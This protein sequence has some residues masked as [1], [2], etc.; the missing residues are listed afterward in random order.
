MGLSGLFLV[1]IA[2]VVLAGCAGAGG[3]AAG[4]PVGSPGGPP[5][6]SGGVIEA[7]EVDGEDRGAGEVVEDTDRGDRA[8]LFDA[9]PGVGRVTVL[10]DLDVVDGAADDSGDRVAVD[11]GDDTERAEVV[12]DIGSGGAVL[13]DTDAGEAAVLYDID[14]GDDTDDGGNDEGVDGLDGD[15][16]DDGGRAV[17]DGDDADAADDVDDSGGDADAVDGVSD[18]G[19][20][21]ADGD[22]GGGSGVRFVVDGF[23]GVLVEGPCGGGGPVCPPATGVAPIDAGGRLV[24]SSYREDW[25]PWVGRVLDMCD[26]HEAYVAL[27]GEH[28]IK[29]DNGIDYSAT[30]SSLD[31]ERILEERGWRPIVCSDA[32]AAIPRWKCWEDDFEEFR[33]FMDEF[34]GVMEYEEV[35]ASVESAGWEC[36]DAAAQRL[37]YVYVTTGGPMQPTS[38]VEAAVEG[39]LA[40]VA[41][42]GARVRGERLGFLGRIP[43]METRE[44]A[45][46]VLPATVS[47]TDGV[48]RGLAQN[49]SEQL[50]ARD[51][52]V[53]ATDPTGGEGEWRFPLTVQPGEPLPFEIENW[54]GTRAASEIDFMITA[55]LSPTIDLTRSLGIHAQEIVDLESFYYEYYDYPEEMGAFP[56][57]E[58]AFGPPDEDAITLAYASGTMQADGFPDG[59]LEW[60][61]IRIERSESSAHPWLTEAAR[62]QTIENLTVYAATREGGVIADVF[63]LTPMTGT[64]V[65][66]EWVEMRTIPFQMPDERPPPRQRVF[67]GVV[68]HTDIY[69]WAGGVA[70]EPRPPGDEPQ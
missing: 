37:R 53:T 63:E 18:A 10:R 35:A 59:Y 3:P 46:V 47:V 27:Y 20:D 28:T 7:A 54:A 50:W 1:A 70:H 29:F 67:V 26:D 38:S 33:A 62:Q 69:L 40:E 48:L 25:G 9:D 65:P 44:D 39:Y 36:W 60:I 52:T 30:I 49:R 56:D 8:V 19:G 24:F 17:G 61:D 4:V 11:D 31:M 21:D 66:G 68:G 41:R 43:A 14:V 23:G 45:L 34:E 51:V 2:V 57:G 13:Y 58:A 22:D 64:T 6:A 16:G 12:D 5:V 55:D 32:G 42:H 15:S